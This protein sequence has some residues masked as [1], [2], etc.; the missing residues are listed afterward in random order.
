[1]DF[2]IIDSALLL[3]AQS[4]NNIQICQDIET[5]PDSDPGAETFTLQASVEEGVDLLTDSVTITIDR[6]Y[7]L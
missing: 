7:N 2:A 3:S 1:M 6:K 4:G 5:F